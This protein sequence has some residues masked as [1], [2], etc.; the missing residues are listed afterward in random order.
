MKLLSVTL[1]GEYKGLG[2]DTFDFSGSKGRL[3][4]FIGLNGSGKSQL[5]ELIGEAFSYLERYK[6]RDFRV[7]RSL[8]CGVSL[9]YQIDV[10]NDP[11]VQAYPDKILESVNYEPT[12]RVSISQE[13]QVAVQGLIDEVWQE[14]K[15]DNRYFPTPYLI[16]YSSGLNENLQ[17]S[18][19]KNAVQFFDV[20]RVRQNRRRELASDINEAGIAQINMRFLKRYPHIFT[21]PQGEALDEDGY[22]S[23]GESDTDI[24]KNLFMDYDSCALLITSFAILNDDE[25]KQIFAEVKFKLPQ[26]IKLKYDLRKG[27]AS[28]DAVRDIRLLIRAG[29]DDSLEGLSGRTSDQVYDLYELD[30]LCGL[31]TLDLSDSAVKERLSSD[32][33]NDPLRLFERLYKLQLL[34][35][36]NWQGD[37]LKKL[38]Q[39]DFIETVKKPLKTRLP[40]S[41][42]RLELADE[43][44]HRVNFDDLSD[45]EAQLIQI[46]AVARIFRDEQTLFLF[47]EPETHLNP[48]WRTYFHQ[49]LSQANRVND[50]WTNKTQTLL[51]THSPFMISSLKKSEVYTFERDDSGTIRMNGA[52]NQTYGASFDVLIKE[53]FKLQSLISQTVVEDIKAHLPKDD[54][55]EERLNARE[56]LTA[57]IGESMEKA[58]LLRKLQD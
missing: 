4:A 1:D 16:G 25:I 17:R 13:G 14:L 44:G 20:M 51:S 24:P 38:R 49:H 9:V 22:L 46:L 42:E 58:Y 3:L 47:D 57:N 35:V 6:R 28:T 23:L 50:V 31:I 18:F 41:I 10:S 39:C 36:S 7:R 32:N 19:M 12:L 27:L 54:S 45:G 40:L 52:E 33:Y 30:Y 56:W 43:S 26:L 11:D 37:N 53:H 48:S 15:L 34:G 5:L 2:S 29:G 55:K 8:G 21:A